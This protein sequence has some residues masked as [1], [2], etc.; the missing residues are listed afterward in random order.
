MKLEIGIVGVFMMAIGG[1][2]LCDFLYKLTTNYFQNFLPSP[3][4]V[5]VVLGLISFLLLGLGLLF[6]VQSG[7]KE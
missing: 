2:V 5:V 7:R 1:A 3:D 6:I 4:W